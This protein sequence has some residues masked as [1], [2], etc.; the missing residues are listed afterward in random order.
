M[1]YIKKLQIQNKFNTFKKQRLS[2]VSVEFM[3]F[4]SVLGGDIAPFSLNS[5]IAAKQYNVYTSCIKLRNC[6]YKTHLT[7]LK[8]QRLSYVSVEFAI[9]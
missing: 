1:H 8:K 9:F 2:Y 7:P 4:Y 5:N 6:K 3:T